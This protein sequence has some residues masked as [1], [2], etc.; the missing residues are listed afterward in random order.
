MCSYNLC[1]HF[2]RCQTDIAMKTILSGNFDHNHAPET[3]RNI[4]RQTIRETVKRKADSDINT[5][6][7]KLIA[8][9]MTSANSSHLLPQDYTAIRQ[10]LYR[11]RAKSRPALPISRQDTC[12][13]LEDFLKSQ[14]QTSELVF[15]IDSEKEIILFSSA[16]ALEIMCDP[17]SETFGDG[18]FGF[19]AKHF[20]Q[21]YT[22]HTVK[23]GY[24]IPCVF[25]LLPSK[26]QAVYE[27][28][29]QHIISLCALHGHV[30][31][32]NSFHV[33][34]ERAMHN[35]IAVLFPETSIS[36]CLFHLCQAWYRK[37]AEIG[38]SKEYKC[39]E[40]ETGAWLK[41]IFG[42]PFLNKEEVEDCFVFDIMA[43]APTDSRAQAFGDYLLHTYI[44]ATSDF[45]PS[46]WATTNLELRTNNSCESFHSRFGKNFY[47][48]HPNVFE[49][50]QAI[51]EE[52][53]LAALKI[54]ASRMGTRV[55]S[56]A[57]RNKV[58]DMKKT[59][60]QYTEGMLS[61]KD[62]VHSMAFR[63]LP[64]MI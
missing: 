14:S 41:S 45:A 20:Y 30:F 51:T 43:E 60:Q 6:P 28:M 19:C 44:L 2:F 1:L 34:F 39:K 5:K 47:Q 49:V 22:V 63:N 61:R 3:E 57:E 54:N 55:T 36:G 58:S 9:E 27:T 37:I 56:K 53:K 59:V 13:K 21:L 7:C 40:S 25:A 11:Q 46:K 31:H 8:S 4:Q 42:L 16:A 12:Q 17:N 24:F 23:N 32:P 48:Q 18:T 33:D 64:P 52:Q 10:A 50:V 29:L 15:S 62:F 35:A 38:L 26:S